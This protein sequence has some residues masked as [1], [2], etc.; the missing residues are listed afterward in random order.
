MVQPVIFIFRR[1]LRFNDN[2]GL[3]RAYEYAI[4]HNLPLRPIFVFNE[5]Q[6]SPTKNKYFGVNTVRF[7][8]ECIEA[9]IAQ[10]TDIYHTTASDIPILKRLKPAAIFFNRDYTPFARKR[11]E[12]I[13]AYANA[14]G[15]HVHGEWTDYSLVD[16]PSMP[17]PY[18]M[19]SLFLADYSPKQYP[20]PIDNEVIIRKFIAKHAP[21]QLHR[22]KKQ[23]DI[24]YMKQ[25]NP[26]VA[27]KGGRS[28]AIKRLDMIRNGTFD[29]YA[30]ARDYPSLQDGTTHL[31]PFLKY[32]ALRGRG[33][34]VAPIIRELFWRTYYEQITFWFPHTL[35][36]QL[37]QN[38][39]NGSLNPKSDLHSWATSRQTQVLASAIMD[40]RT[41]IPIVD[42]AVA[43]LTTTGYMHNRMRMV[44]CMLAS[45]ILNLDWRTFERWFAQHLIDYY[46]SANSGGWQWS[47]S[48]RFVLNPWVQQ[49][50]FD[51]DADYIKHYLP[52]LSHIP[53][54]HLHEMYDH[55]HEYNQPKP[56][57]GR[58]L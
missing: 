42:A 43:Q 51:K 41:G 34:S 12:E 54:K 16:I 49:A 8:V 52:H 35:Q 27:F 6:V 53:P 36:G 39:P 5:I 14:N 57:I 46:P 28:E 44:V 31:S 32:H 58:T 23:L 7:M 24:Y 47:M 15:I 21:K 25:K 33:P 30:H 29:K 13:I 18:R 3:T 56:I 22:D 11:D 37:S 26:H 1:D 9:D 4:A 45:R 50:K 40:G 17:K 2:I 19:Y 55:Y 10:L 20:K 48:Y 38:E